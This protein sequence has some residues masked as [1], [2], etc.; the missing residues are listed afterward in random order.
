MPDGRRY[1]WLARQVESGPVG[2]GNRRKTFAVSLG[3][4][5]RHADRLVYSRGLDLHG[6]RDATPIGPGCKVCERSDCVQRAFPALRLGSP[7]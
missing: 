2:Y 4:E 7:G 3:C 1:F 6:T 5:L